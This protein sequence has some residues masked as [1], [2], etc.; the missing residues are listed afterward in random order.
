MLMHKI[1]K[2]EV[3]VFMLKFESMNI[4]SILLHLVD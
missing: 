1:S 4:L 2:K 3:I